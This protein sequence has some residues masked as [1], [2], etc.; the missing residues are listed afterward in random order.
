MRVAAHANAVTARA[1]SSAGT[2]TAASSKVRCWFRVRF[3][4]TTFLN[5]MTV[6]YSV[7]GSLPACQ[8]RTSVLYCSHAAG[9]RRVPGA[10]ATADPGR[11][12]ALLRAPGLLRDIDAGRVPRGGT[13]GGGRATVLQEQGPASPGRAIPPPLPSVRP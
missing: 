13:V 3:I 4:C 2:T 10:A 1:A 7:F 5:R 9:Q 12:P 11:R 6:L 8:E